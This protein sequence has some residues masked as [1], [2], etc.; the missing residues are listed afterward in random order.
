MLGE[1]IGLGMGLIGGIGKLFSSGRSNREMEQ[2]MKQNPV[3]KAN[4]MAAQRLG[5]A[6]TLLNGRSPGAATVENNIFRSQANTTSNINRVAT[7][8]GTALALA[9]EGQGKTN[10]ALEKLGL[11]EKEDYQRK[12]NNMEQAQEGV[13]RE[14][15]KV[16]QDGV[17]RFQDKVQLKGAQQQNRDSNWQS[18][19]NLGFGLAN[20]SSQGGFDFLK[21][22]GG[23]SG[24]GYQGSG[25]APMQTQFG[26]FGQVTPSILNPSYKSIFGG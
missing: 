14:D 17:R 16:F 13:I 23:G 3:Y 9:T 4:P 7:D 11:M 15:D 26:N 12:Y 24:G 20:F 18:I 2:L 21:G 10:D 5:L 25:I 1:A 19:S 8:S 6:Q 22:N